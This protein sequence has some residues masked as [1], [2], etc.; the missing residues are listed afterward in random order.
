MFSFDVQNGMKQ[1]KIREFLSFE[2]RSF[3]TRLN[4]IRYIRN[5]SL[6]QF[7]FSEFMGELNSHKHPQFTHN[8]RLKIQIFSKFSLSKSIIFTLGEVFFFLNETNTAISPFLYFV[9]LITS[10]RALFPRFSSKKKKKNIPKKE[11]RKKEEKKRTFS[12]HLAS[13]LTAFSRP[14]SP[15]LV[16]VFEHLVSRDPF[17]PPFHRSSPLQTNLLRQILLPNL[18]CGSMWCSERGRRR[19]QR[20]ASNLGFSRISFKDFDDLDY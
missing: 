11:K 10:S 18:E 3:C 14:Q 17:L 4:I 19:F 16:P 2:I 1:H 6:F 12:A 13:F 9:G 5:K 7:H 20:R 8:L 15:R